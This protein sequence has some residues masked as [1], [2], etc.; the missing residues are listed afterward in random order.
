MPVTAS[1]FW[2]VPIITQSNAN[3]CWF[4]CFQMIYQFWVNQGSAGNL[5]DPGNVDAT[6][7]MYQNNVP[8]R[9]AQVPSIASALGYTYLYASLDADGLGTLMSK[10]PI[11]YLGIN[12]LTP[13]PAGHAVVLNG[14]SNNLLAV[15]D[16]WD[17]QNYTFSDCDLFLG[18]VLPQ[19]GQAP[20]V[21]PP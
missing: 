1:Y 17:G 9:G 12:A 18:T 11:M 13:N 7:S 10:G 8:L 15:I 4:A 6:F 5:Q 3:V 21:Y 19:S 20:L 2:N 16:P 14:I